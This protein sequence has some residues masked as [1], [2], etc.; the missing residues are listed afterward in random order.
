MSI[1][2]QTLLKNFKH[3][4]Q[5]RS[6]DKERMKKNIWMHRKRFGLIVEKLSKQGKLKTFTMITF[7]MREHYDE[8]EYN[9][10]L[11]RIRRVFN[12]Y[13]IGRITTTEF[14]KQGRKHVH[15]LITNVEAEKLRSTKSF[16]RFVK[17]YKL[18]DDDIAGLQVR[19]LEDILLSRWIASIWKLGFVDVDPGTKAMY[20]LKYFKKGYSRVTY[21]G[22]YRKL[23]RGLTSLVVITWNNQFQRIKPIF[24]LPLFFIKGVL[25]SARDSYLR[26][27]RLYRWYQYRY[28]FLKRFHMLKPSQFAMLLAYAERLGLILGY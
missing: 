7:T 17:N 18:T 11:N 5:H 12:Y 13:K 21:S 26:A 15:M 28:D 10:G 24:L 27:I 14:T 19:S 4:I 20:L 16:Q 22:K 6:R 23:L 25:N 8:I 9:H 3:D 2:K 1:D